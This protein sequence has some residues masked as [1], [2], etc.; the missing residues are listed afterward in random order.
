VGTYWTVDLG[1]T[2]GRVMTAALAG[3]RVTLHEET[4]F[5]NQPR[6]YGGALFWDLEEL[7]QQTLTGLRRAAAR[8]RDYGE[9]PAGVAVDSWGVD[10]ALVDGSGAIG[11]A[12]HY[13]SA[14][15]A[16][17]ARIQ[18][19]V[20]AA[21]LFRRSG[22][23]PMDINTVFRL[24]DALAEL[25]PDAAGAT[26][27]LIPDLWTYRLSG[28]RGAELTIAGTTGLLDMTT[29]TWDRDLLGL[30]G[31]DPGVLPGLHASGTRAGSL[32]P[33]VAADLGVDAEVPVLRGAGHDTAAA[34]AA[35]PGSGPVAFISCG[36]WAL[37]GVET[38]QP[39]LSQEA[40][41][42][43]F[44]NELGAGGR[45]LFMRNLTGLWLLE[46]A[47]RSWRRGDPALSLDALLAQAGDVSGLTSVI[48]V[49]APS[50]VHSA[51]VQAQIRAMC[52]GSGQ[53]VP[54]SAPEMVRC[55]LLSL[56][57]AFR[58][59]LL[60]CERHTG[61]PVNEVHLVGGGTRNTLLCQLVADT[62]ALPVVA[63][64]AEAT[65][66]G[67]ALIQAWGCGE[68]ESAGHIREIAGHSHRP[69]T[70]YPRTGASRVI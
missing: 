10:F 31:L 67:N 48:D 29:R 2:S 66:L 64:P 44:T 69:V 12:R 5:A 53:R 11:P 24:G 9:A 17:A 15:P 55:I 30:L 3:D 65:S 6:E 16:A 40:L 23:A 54:Q 70:Y 33:G 26:M 38:A 7:W 39:V 47:Y 58:Q 14:P 50:L 36:T 35:I 20:G 52:S 61:V 51:D 43:G 41:R 68:V 27:L 37:A 63:G 49:G 13:R 59:T 8:A 45:V 21:E 18:E 56:A 32:L 62:C 34:V 46:Q 19:R 60:D 1:A 22:V 4:R 57:V 28:V 25:G 42:G